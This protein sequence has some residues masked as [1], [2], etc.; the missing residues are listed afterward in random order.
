MNWKI[1]FV[2]SALLIITASC[3]QKSVETHTV[4]I[5]D[6]VRHVNNNAPQWGDEPRVSLEFVQKIGDLDTEDDNFWLYRPQ[7]VAVDGSGNIY[8]VD[9]GNSRIQKY[10][11]NGKYLSTFGRRGQ[12]PSE[13]IGPQG[14]QVT[15]DKHLF[16]LDVGRTIELS[17]TGKE[18]RRFSEINDGFYYFTVLSSGEFL[19]KDKIIQYTEN[20]NHPFNEPILKV[21][22]DSCNIIRQFCAPLDF[23]VWSV[24]RVMNGVRYTNDEQDNIYVTFT[25]QNRIEKYTLGGQLTWKSDRLLG[26][27]MSKPEPE[28]IQQAPTGEIRAARVYSGPTE[29]VFSK[30]IEVDGQGRLW[31][32]TVL[33]QEKGNPDSENYT[34][35]EE[36][37]ELYDPDGFLLYR[38]PLPEINVYTKLIGG[39]QPYRIFGDRIFFIDRDIEMAVYEYRI[40]EK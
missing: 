8:I 34:P 10:D 28:R 16:V 30:H 17:P 36:I 26:Y 7:D 23:E 3:R 40:V 27:E 38:L 4:D 39:R 9:S 24:S 22:D 25:K 11:K 31:V 6:G 2:C 37:L 19:S 13:F 20:D 33:K 12:G 21:F 15:P 1:I 35:E 32:L 14:I 29:N 18:I 5:I